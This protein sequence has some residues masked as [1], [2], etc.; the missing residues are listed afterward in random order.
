[1]QIEK[2]TFNARNGWSG[3]F[4]THMDSPQTLIFLFGSSAYLSD[5]RPVSQL[6][7]NFPKSHSVGCSAA[8]GIQNSGL[9]DDALIVSIVRF[10][11]TRLKTAVAPVIEASDSFKAGE[12]LAQLLKGE[13]LKGVIVFSDGLNVNGTELVSGINTALPPS[14][15]VTGGLAADDDRFEATWVLKDGEPTTKYVSA[16]GFY[17]DNIRIGHGSKDGFDIF[18]ME[19]KVTRSYK[20]QLFELDGQPA[21]DL[22]KAYLGDRASELPASALQFP[23]SLRFDTMDDKRVVR[24]ILNIDEDS[25][26]MIFAG[27]VPEGAM[28]Q[29]MRANLDRLID[30]A[31]EAAEMAST[32]KDLRDPVLSLAIS[33]VGRRWILGMRAEEELDAVMDRLPDGSTQIGF[34]SYGEISPHDKGFCDLH[35]QTMTLTTLFEV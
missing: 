18:G 4:P 27:D 31:S 12:E 21:L 15:K 3:E 28:A 33:C 6:L 8:G 1:M 32:D 2:L 10:D 29:L 24:T 13:N 22:Y 20:N 16:V 34:Y 19:R 14:I 25:K 30:G 17:G 9:S 26:S 7:N 35:N 5:S 23:L 11:K